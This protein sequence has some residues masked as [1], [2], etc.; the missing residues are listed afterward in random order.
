MS[1]KLQV[2]MPFDDTWYDVTH[3]PARYLKR[4]AR[5]DLEEQR[6]NFPSDY[7]LRIVNS[8]GEVQ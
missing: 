6:H 7:Q 3:L 2:L 5:K 4:T 1:Y 8:K